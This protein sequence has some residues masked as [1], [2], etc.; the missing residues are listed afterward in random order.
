MSALDFLDSMV[1]SNRITPSGC[2]IMGSGAQRSR[3]VD[4]TLARRNL[5]QV[6]AWERR[7][8]VRLYLV[9]KLSMDAIGREMVM[10]DGTVRA[11]LKGNGIELREGVT[12]DSA[13]VLK[14]RKGCA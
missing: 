7:E 13:G 10:T 5:K 4:R 11:I 2:I 8:V 9:E 3:G 1:R 6:V 12:C 14:Q